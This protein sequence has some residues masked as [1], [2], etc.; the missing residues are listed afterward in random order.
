MLPPWLP[1]GFQPCEVHRW[2][3]EEGGG[4]TGSRNGGH[5]DP[6]ELLAAFDAL[7][8]TLNLCLSLG[9]ISMISSCAINVSFGPTWPLRKRKQMAA[10]A[11]GCAECGTTETPNWRGE[12]CTVAEI[13]SNGRRIRGRLAAGPA[14]VL[15]AVSERCRRPRPSACTRKSRRHRC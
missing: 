15:A 8:R 12:W 14:V 9:S 3:K 7:G 1:R 4:V 6:N 11:R 2:F 13:R 5:R 10:D